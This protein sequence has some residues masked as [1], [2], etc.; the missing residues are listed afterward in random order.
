MLERFLVSKKFAAL[1]LAFSIAVLAAVS[2]SKSPDVPE[3]D[4][5]APTVSPVG[6]SDP[7]PDSPGCELAWRSEQVTG[8]CRPKIEARVCPDGSSWI[9]ARELRAFGS[10]MTTAEFFPPCHPDTAAWAC[11][12]GAPDGR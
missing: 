9:V 5:P 7:F 3:I 1:Y 10:C 12:N 4:L 2:P 8:W 11:P 6:G